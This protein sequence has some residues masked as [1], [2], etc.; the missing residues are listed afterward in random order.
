M[1]QDAARAF[2]V[3]DAQEFGYLQGKVVVLSEDQPV[4]KDFH[5]QALQPAN[6]S[7]KPSNSEPN[8]SQIFFLLIATWVKL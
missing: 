4:Q 6:G 8:I 3:R 2:G 5:R 1:R 7:G